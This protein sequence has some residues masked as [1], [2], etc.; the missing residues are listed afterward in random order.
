MSDET[1]GYERIS[2]SVPRE[3]AEE[4]RGMKDDKIIAS[5]SAYVSHSVTGQI[6]RDRRHRE[7]LERRRRD[8]GLDDRQS[9]L[10]A[11]WADDVTD[12][13]TKLSYTEYVSAQQSA[14]A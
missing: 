3:L 12:G 10:A 6:D 9:A 5:V 13:R 1:S 11:Q 14:A 2:I 4:L 7:S 8:F